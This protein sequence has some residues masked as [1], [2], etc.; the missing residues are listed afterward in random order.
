MTSTDI[1]NR[2]AELES[3]KTELSKERRAANARFERAK[4]SLIAGKLES[5]ADE[6]ND[7]QQKIAIWDSTFKTIDEQLTALQ[8]EL[9]IVLPKEK[10]EII[11]N[12]LVELSNEATLTVE[13]YVK[14]RTELGDLLEISCQKLLA[15]ERQFR[16]TKREFENTFSEVVPNY[17]RAWRSEPEIEA[18]IEAVFAELVERGANLKAVRSR[19]FSRSSGRTLLDS[20]FQLPEH[21][22]SEAIY[23]AKE[24]AARR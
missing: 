20:D 4:Q 5:K 23:T 7:L 2:I 18:Q 12:A 14:N 21:E 17:Q 11:L 9:E 15:D 6:L 22:F 3:R 19:L 24:I 13:S 10:R 1:K 8:T 16:A